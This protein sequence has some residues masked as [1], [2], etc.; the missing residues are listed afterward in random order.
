MPTSY[1]QLTK[2]KI[3]SRKLTTLPCP[4][5]FPEK[6]KSRMLKYNKNSD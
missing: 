3:S 5:Q 6:K 1:T 2:Y 4:R